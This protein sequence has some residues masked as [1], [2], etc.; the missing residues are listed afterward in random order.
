MVIFDVG[1]NIGTYSGKLL[2]LGNRLA[3][4]CF[5]PIPGTFQVLQQRLSSPSGQSSV[6]LN[7]IGLSDHQA[8]ATMYLCHETAGT[9]SLYERKSSPRLLQMQ[10]ANQPQPVSLITLDDYVVEHCIPSI[11]LLKID[12]EGHELS[13]LQGAAT[14]LRE[15]RI[16]CIQ[17][18]Y[19]DCFLDAGITLEEVYSLLAGY[20]YQI[21]R[22]YPFGKIAVRKFHASLENY[23]YSNW[24]ALKR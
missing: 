2:E 18:E 9:N 22:L 4:H 15:Q 8:T 19:N 14:L 21:Y 16:T 6:H 20:G 10:T 3:V 11:D 12:V 7:N 24:L 23:L 1:A 5:E 17:F 13:V